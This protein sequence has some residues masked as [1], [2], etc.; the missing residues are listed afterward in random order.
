MSPL[1]HLKH[2]DFYQVYIAGVV[3]PRR[4]EEGLDR[5]HYEGSNYCGER[6]GNPDRGID[7]PGLDNE[8]LAS[9]ASISKFN[10][11]MNYNPLGLKEP[12]TN[13]PLIWGEPLRDKVSLTLRGV[14]LYTV[15]ILCYVECCIR[16]LWCCSI[17]LYSI[18]STAHNQHTDI[19]PLLNIYTFI[20]VNLGLQ[21]YDAKPDDGRR[22]T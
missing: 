6:S 18:T 14:F 9:N 12:L 5:Q 16:Q 3:Y 10:Q 17:I 19:Y 4:P 20:S 21:P 2:Y 1:K 7:D 22:S 13:R 15:G 8:D 11:L